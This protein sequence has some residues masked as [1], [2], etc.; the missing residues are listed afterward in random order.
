MPE[1]HLARDEVPGQIR[2]RRPSE[3]AGPSDPVVG[4]DGQN[5]QGFMSRV[6]RSRSWM[7][8]VPSW[9]GLRRLSR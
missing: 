9:I 5:Q 4:A 6:V 7:P 1:T 3:A 8:W 2:T